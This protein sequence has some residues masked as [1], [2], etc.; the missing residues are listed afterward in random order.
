MSFQ[1]ELAIGLGFGAMTGIFNFLAL[2]FAVE[3]FALPGSGLAYFL[4]IILTGSNLLV[5]GI[6]VFVVGRGCADAT[7]PMPIKM[8]GD[9]KDTEAPRGM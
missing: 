3:Y 5:F 6:G 8:L 4:A 9:W 1:R 7:G 2:G